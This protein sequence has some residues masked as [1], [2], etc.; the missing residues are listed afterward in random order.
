MHMHML[1]HISMCI[2]IFTSYLKLDQKYSVTARL[3][4]AE[5]T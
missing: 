4:V 1:S 3:A 2:Y 5:Y